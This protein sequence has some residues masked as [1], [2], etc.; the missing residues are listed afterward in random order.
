[1]DN[2]TEHLYDNFC[3][4]RHGSALILSQRVAIVLAKRHWKKAEDFSGHPSRFESFRWKILRETTA[5]KKAHVCIL[6]SQSNA[7]MKISEVCACPLSFPTSRTTCFTLGYNKL[8][9]VRNNKEKFQRDI[10]KFS[11]VIQKIPNNRKI[12]R[13]TSVHVDS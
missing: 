13:P 11:K 3:L 6:C 4:Q 12:R 2:I 5:D 1:M 8:V 10:K 9:T 7:M